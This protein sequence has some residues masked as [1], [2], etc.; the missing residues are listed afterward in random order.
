[1]CAKTGNLVQQVRIFI[2]ERFQ[3]HF[4]CKCARIALRFLPIFLLA[5][6]QTHS[7]THKG[8]NALAPVY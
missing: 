8:W 5:K 4:V 1:M 3:C 2:T 7:Y 6:R